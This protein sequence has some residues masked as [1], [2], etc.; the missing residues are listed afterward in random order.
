MMN[1]IIFAALL[2]A[3]G[4]CYVWLGV[5]KN[6]RAAQIKTLYREIDDLKKQLATATV[7][8]G[9]KLDTRA[10][11]ERV[12]HADL[13]LKPIPIGPRGGRLVKL[14][15]PEI[16]TETATPSSGPLSLATTLQP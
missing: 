2:T 6:E 4:G 13:D 1:C 16:K 8:I 14:P 9:R 5:K 15:E 12:A 7:D 3:I 10:L 11:G